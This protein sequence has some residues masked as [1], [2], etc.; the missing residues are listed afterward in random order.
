MPYRRLPNT[1]LARLRALKQA[2]V[3]T[4]GTGSANKLVSEGICLKVRALTPVFEQDV[5][6][7]NRSKEQQ[8]E[9][10]KKLDSLAKQARL[11]LSHYL[12]VFNMCVVRGEI[13]PETRLMLGLT[14]LSENLPQFDTN[15]LLIEWGDKVVKG[16]EERTLKGLGNRIY[17]PSIAVVKVKLEQF[18]EVYNQ[19]QDL[20]RTIEKHH[21]RV[22]QQREQIDEFVRVLWDEIESGAAE[23]ASSN[24]Q[25][26]A[27]AQEYGVVYAYR[28]DEK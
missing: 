15:A 3:A 20:L 10:S 19:N 8:S 11:Y 1:D 23:I 24:D 4:A 13:K 16:E 2:M 26:R 14:E 5:D 22:E 17:N 12:Q 7:Y 21:Q 28:P 6:V 25:K 9:L 27:L 18:K